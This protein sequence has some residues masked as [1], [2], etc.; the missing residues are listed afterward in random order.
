MNKNEREVLCL[1]RLGTQKHLHLLSG[2]SSSSS[3]CAPSSVEYQ[4]S[5][6]E[7]H[8]MRTQL[9]KLEARL[10]A[11][12]KERED[13]RV[14]LETERKTREDLQQHMKRELQ[15]FMKNWHPPNN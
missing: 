11:E 5:V 6:E 12:T 9:E 7:A 1:C 15:D 14:H 4:R 13:L 8:A 2:T 10:E 3:G